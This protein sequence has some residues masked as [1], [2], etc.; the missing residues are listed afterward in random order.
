MRQLYHRFA[1]I[2]KLSD[3][4]SLLL[5][6]L[7]LH[8]FNLFPVAFAEQVVILLGL[9]L[10]WFVISWFT[11]LYE[12]AYVRYAQEHL[13][14]LAKTYIVF[15]SVSLSI[16]FLL[17]EILPKRKAILSAI[18]ICAVF[19]FIFR[20][21][22]FLYRRKYRIYL[23]RR[24]VSVLL[25]KSRDIEVFLRKKNFRSS[26]GIKG[27]YTVNAENDVGRGKY[28][29]DLNDLLN[30][31]NEN[32][33]DNII[34]CDTENFQEDYKT[35][36]KKAD[37]QMVR[38]YLLPALISNVPSASLN[39]VGDVA[40]FKMIPEPLQSLEKALL[41]RTFDI[42]FSLVVIIFI[43]SWLTPII[44]IIIRAES[45][46]P[47][48]FTQLRSG[49]DNKPFKC[50]KFRTM[51]VND[52]SDTRLVAKNDDRITK[53][54]AFLRKT[55]IDEFPQ[56]FNVLLGDMSVVGPRPMMLSVTEANKKIIEKFNVRHFVKPGITGWAQVTGS[57]GEIFSEEDMQRRIEK[58][59]WYIQNW[60]FFL[61]LKII[62]LT[63]YN[64]IKGDE[65]AY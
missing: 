37:D 31:L 57:R 30:D 43:L 32:N 64:L 44:A 19:L 27:F 29:G 55:S 18:V 13:G 7:L 62:F 46:G 38:I 40:L 22:T 63:V 50:F 15:S 60:S 4:I 49:L 36:L 8:F 25:G 17:F 28:L 21:L 52:E 41:K 33:I 48:F 51:R 11:K 26:L 6:F 61:D 10:I 14:V 24:L 54:G 58:D 35:V 42:I 39:I 56:F 34:L 65:Q 2:L 47:V 45:K 9:L 23:N 53:I 5:T 12:N 20:I 1:S 16:Y 3:A 59:V